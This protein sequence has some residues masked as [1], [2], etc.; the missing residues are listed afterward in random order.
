LVSRK[1]DTRYEYNLWAVA[2]HATASNY[3]RKLKLVRKILLDSYERDDFLS[4][5]S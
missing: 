5:T 1:K 3:E 2:L 4:E